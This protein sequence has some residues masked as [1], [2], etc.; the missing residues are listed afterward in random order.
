[1]IAVTQVERVRVLRLE[2]PPSNELDL[3]LLARLRAEARAAA[4]DPGTRC[5]V[6]ASALPKYFSSGLDVAEMARLP[7]GDEAKLFLSLL[8]TY[9]ELRRLPKPT[10]AAIGGSAVL[11]GWIIA[12]ACDVRLMTPEGRVALSEI[13]YGLTPSSLLVQRALSLGGDARAV[14]DLVLRGR[15]L[16]ADEAAAAGLVDRV[17]A[18]EV[19]EAES[20]KEARALARMAPAAYASVK[21]SLWPEDE[22][23]WQKSLAE[24][25]E[26]LAGE[27]A[28]EGLAALKEKRRPRW[29]E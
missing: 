19:L 8:D 17:V 26:T 21:R 23:L 10:L 22:A 13:R 14:K 7:A 20:L 3:S 11:G 28:R 29:E 4:E 6:L 5:L 1:M 12:M 15:A 18:A 27:E 2:R 16:R 9:R 25:R 24:F